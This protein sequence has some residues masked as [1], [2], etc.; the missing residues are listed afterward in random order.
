MTVSTFI[1]E[2]LNYDFYLSQYSTDSGEDSTP[3]MTP[4]PVTAGS[5]VIVIVVPA[6]ALLVITISVVLIVLLKRTCKL[7]SLSK[8]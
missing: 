2:L 1:G 7:P 5:S 8:C 6:G 4:R 3:S